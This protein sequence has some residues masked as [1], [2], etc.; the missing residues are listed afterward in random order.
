VDD[1]ICDVPRMNQGSHFY[2]STLS[3]MLCIVHCSYTVVERGQFPGSC[4]LFTTSGGSVGQA[5]N[6]PP[7][8]KCLLSVWSP[9]LPD[10]PRVLLSLAAVG[11]LRPLTKSN[12]LSLSRT[13]CV[14]MRSLYSLAELSIT[15]TRYRR[16]SPPQT[17][18]R[19]TSREPLVTWVSSQ[20]MSHLSNRYALA[21]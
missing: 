21:S 6:E 2:V 20:T 14:Y 9:P 13:R 15:P 4:H 17:S 8:N 3:S 11:M 7:R 12:F 16:Y 5:C 18:C 1:G 19:S 10:V